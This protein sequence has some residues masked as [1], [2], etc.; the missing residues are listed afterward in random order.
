MGPKP[1]PTNPFPLSGLPYSTVS[2]LS[3][4][5]FLLVA[6]HLNGWKLDRRYGVILMIWYLIFITVASMYELNVFGNMN[7]RVCETDY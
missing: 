2:L 6:T 1:P 7:P 5:I 3:T 4:V